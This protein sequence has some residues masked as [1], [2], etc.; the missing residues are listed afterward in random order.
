VPDGYVLAVVV[1]VGLAVDDPDGLGL[2]SPIVNVVVQLP[3]LSNVSALGLLLGTFG[4]TDVCL[5]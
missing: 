5:N 4:A 3:E 1:A 2:T